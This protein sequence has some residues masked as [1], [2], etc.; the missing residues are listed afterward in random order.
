LKHFRFRKKWKS[1][2][3]RHKAIRRLMW[4]LSGNWSVAEVLKL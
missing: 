1:E 2:V 4:L 3:F